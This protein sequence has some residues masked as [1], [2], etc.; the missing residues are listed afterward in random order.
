MEQG[1]DAESGEKIVDLTL[2]K[3]I[4]LS[5]GGNLAMRHLGPFFLILL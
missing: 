3:N 2:N 4:S 1:P 5:L